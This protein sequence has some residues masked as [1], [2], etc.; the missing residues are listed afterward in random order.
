MIFADPKHCAKMRIVHCGVDPAMYD[1]PAG[2]A[3]GKRAIFVGRLAA[4]KGVRVLLEAF[5][6]LRTAHPD[7]WLTL[8]GDGG[9][10]K[11]LE[12]EATRLGLLDMVDFAGFRSQD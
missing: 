8:V 3:G 1:A 5:A 6:A 4:I 9:E 11:G 12:A 2:G 10:R 7:A